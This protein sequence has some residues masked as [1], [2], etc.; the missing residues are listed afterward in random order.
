MAAIEA[1]TVAEADTLYEQYGRPLEPDHN[2]KYLAI[3]PNGKIVVGN[4]LICVLDRAAGELGKGHV[5]FK[6]GGP[7]VY[8]WLSVHGYKPTCG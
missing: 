5:V 1:M 6:V 7:S 8:K 3:S 2:G 4:D